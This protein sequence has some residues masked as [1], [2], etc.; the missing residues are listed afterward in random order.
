MIYFQIL[1]F[2]QQFYLF[3]S[4]FYQNLN[5][6]SQMNYLMTKMRNIIYKI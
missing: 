3:I 1:Q 2:L 5:T 6:Q 4:Q